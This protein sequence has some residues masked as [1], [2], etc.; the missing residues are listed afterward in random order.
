MLEY[1]KLLQSREDR[2]KTGLALEKLVN[3]TAIGSFNQP[4]ARNLFGLNHRIQPSPLPLNR[5][6]HGIAFFTRPRLNLTD[7]N[8]RMDRRLAWLKTSETKSINNYI[9]CM[10]DPELQIKHNVVCPF[11]DPYMSFIPILTNTL[12]SLT[13]WRDIAPAI[14]QYPEGL[15]RESQTFIDGPTLDYAP[16]DIAASFRNIQ[17]NIVTKMLAVWLHYAFFV[18]EGRLT[19]YP[20]Y[21]WNFEIDYNT[22]IFKLSLDTTKTYVTSILSTI[23]YPTNAPTGATGNY[24][25]NAPFNEANNQLAINFRA[26]GTETLD[27]IL[28]L[29]FNQIVQMRNP[30]MR[31]GERQ[32]K[33]HKLVGKELTFFNNFGYPHIDLRTKE[34]SYWIFKEHYNT[35]K[36]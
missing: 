27:D 30:R 28:F 26:H 5:D 33:M 13:N 23:A 18:F 20:E 19:P 14:Y 10:L 15:Y 22:R 29:E 32:E 1:S 35:F 21:W 9:R 11:V 6:Q 7:D 25:A 16:Y 34:L 2:E 31:D 3:T 24:E 12:E 8:I 4:I 17:G 36:V